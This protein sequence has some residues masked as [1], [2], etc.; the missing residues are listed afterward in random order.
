M[1]KQMNNP[2][3][4]QDM[5][6]QMNN[7][8]QNQ[9]MMNNMLQQKMMQQQMQQML[10][11]QAMQQQNP[12]MMSNM[13][14]MQNMQ[15]MQNIQ[16]MPNMSNN[17][18][19]M[20]NGGNF[21]MGGN[22][23]DIEG[24]LERMQAERDDLGM[25]MGGNFNPMA[26]QNQMNMNG[27]SGYYNQNFQMGGRGGY[28]ELHEQIND[29]KK[30]I[31]NR[32]GFNPEMMMN[33]TS[34]EIDE[35]L[36]K[37]KN[38]EN[39]DSLEN[40]KKFLEM[41]KETRNDIKKNKKKLDKEMK[42][43]IKKMK[44]S[45]K[46]SDSESYIE[47]NFDDET[48][49]SNSSTIDSD[50]DSRKNRTKR[51]DV[52]N[53]SR[54]NVPKKNV[55]KKDAAKKD[56]VKKD[57]VKKDTI[58]KDV[59][60]KDVVK[61]DISN[62]NTKKDSKKG[63]LRRNDENDETDNSDQEST[64]NNESDKDDEETNSVDNNQSDSEDNKK[65]NSEVGGNNYMN[66]SESEL[67]DE[68]NEESSENYENRNIQNME[69]SKI[70]ISIDSGDYTEPDFFND[71]VYDFEK[72]INNP[73]LLE[74]K[75]GEF[76]M[77]KPII[78]DDNN[79]L[80]VS[81]NGKGFHCKLDM[82]D[83]DYSIGNL[84][85]GINGILEKMDIQISEDKEN[86]IIFSSNSG[87]FILDFKENSIGF[88]LGFE[89]EMYEGK[90]KYRSENKHIFLERNYFMFIKEFSDNPICR[91]S[92]EGNVKQLTKNFK[93]ETKKIKQLTIQYRY[94]K[95]RESEL[96]EFY[97]SPHKLKFTITHTIDSSE[98]R[99]TKK[100]KDKKGNKR[101]NISRYA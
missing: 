76:P 60:K 56:V 39:E 75:E 78:N 51:K 87:K 55:I 94:G 74:I 46:Y 92:A 31:A 7:P 16:N 80:V 53:I 40:K 68:S 67:E 1:M 19:W 69:T 58:K 35:M 9:D 18:N 20:N 62:R 14:N 25:N 73:I 64:N 70:K 42:T 77:L 47:E 50:D 86:H 4:N 66:D 6:K 96:V 57:V 89:E 52:K 45:R 34:D 49:E 99:V 54:N 88:F 72:E 95:T 13:S 11:Q 8:M 2:M 29:K 43:N 38:R 27:G 22:N 21:Q 83:D 61:K 79:N 65:S 98:I 3:K 93:K 85:T 48:D 84:V 17:R 81:K 82:E 30:E 59:V 63:Y 26:M 24:K 33:M 101:K 10:H 5:M 71:Y 91:I 32:V 100:G 28:S 36:K 15:N 37:D 90:K 23:N 41:L 12:N 97:D 44:K